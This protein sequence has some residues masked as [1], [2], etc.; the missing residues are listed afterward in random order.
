M[1]VETKKQQDTDVFVNKYAKIKE[2]GEILDELIEEIENPH[3]VLVGTGKTA[4]VPDLSVIYFLNRAK[5]KDGKVTIVDKDTPEELFKNLVWRYQKK[6]IDLS[7]NVEYINGEM[8]ELDTLVQESADLVFYHN[9][10]MYTGDIQKTF[11]ASCNT[12]SEKNGYVVFALIDYQ[13]SSIVKEENDPVGI[14]RERNEELKKIAKKSKIASMFSGIKNDYYCDIK[15]FD[16]EFD[17]QVNKYLK[18]WGEEL[19]EVEEDI[20]KEVLVPN[21]R[22]STMVIVRP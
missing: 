12:V 16:K 2:S 22:C 20:K 21:F 15:G 13:E 3:F 9:S 19:E 7:S 6:D 11:D 4:E 5:Q 10:I 18:Y 14:Y 1:A 17:E 8:E